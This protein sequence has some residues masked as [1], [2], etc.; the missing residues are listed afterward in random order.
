LDWQ[1]SPRAS[2]QSAQET[3]DE[4]PWDAINTP[5]STTRDSHNPIVSDPLPQTAPPSSH[6]PL[7]GSSSQGDIWT[8]SDLS[9]HSE[10]QQGDLRYNLS[11]MM[12]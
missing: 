12:E 6:A 4:I 3:S 1:S 7:N 8:L 5:A 10:S 9:V 11:S 2:P